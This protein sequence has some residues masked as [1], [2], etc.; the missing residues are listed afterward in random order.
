LPSLWNSRTIREIYPNIFDWLNL[1]DQTVAIVINIMIVVALLNLIT[2]LIILVLERTRMVG[3]LKALGAANPVIQRIF[4]FH[5][6]FITIAGILGGNL[7]ALGICWLQTRYGFIRLPEE[8]YYISKAEVIL[9]WWQVLAVDLGT[10]IICFLVLTIPTMIIR[11]VQ[12][13]KAIQFR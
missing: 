12:P 2:C 7:I 3:I 13:V 5:G 6:A 4:L 10:F 11:R 8:M 9:E 1:Q